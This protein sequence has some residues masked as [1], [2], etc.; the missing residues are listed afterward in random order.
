MDEIWVDIKNYEGLYKISNFGRVMSMPK[1][2]VCCKKTTRTKSETIV[3]VCTNTLYHNLRLHKKGE[4]SRFKNLHRLLAEHFIP[5]PN[6]KREVNH[7]NGNKHD[8][9]L[10]N[11]EWVTS[12]EN[13]KHA[14]DTGLKVSPKSKNHH[15]AKPI[16]IIN[17]KKCT[18][19]SFPTIREAVEKTGISTSTIYMN[20]KGFSKSWNYKFEYL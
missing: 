15:A 13:R 12:S 5:N 17:T 19:I 4:K 10:E 7:I 1:T 14:F 11:L 16:M 2:W 20:M 18:T 3:S 8:N 9:R 6:N